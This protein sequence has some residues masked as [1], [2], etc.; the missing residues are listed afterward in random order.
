MGV[1][2]FGWRISPALAFE[3]ELLAYGKTAGWTQFT[4]IRRDVILKIVEIVA[5]SGTQFAALTQL[6]YLSRDVGIRG[7]KGDDDVGRLTEVGVPT[8]Q[9]VSIEPSSS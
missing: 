4:S 3:L 5:A 7:E 1:R 8:S 2:G 6:T 9:S